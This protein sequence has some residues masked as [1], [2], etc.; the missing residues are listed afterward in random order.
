MA[1]PFLKIWKSHS[2]NIYG[3]GWGHSLNPALIVI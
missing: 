3:A 2:T 1:F